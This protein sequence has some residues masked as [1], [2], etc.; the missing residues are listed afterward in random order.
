M[1]LGIT[2]VNVGEPTRPHISVKTALFASSVT[3]LCTASA[4]DGVN[5][6]LK[7][8]VRYRSLMTDS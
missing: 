4:A 8:A 1:C 6:A 7:N 3:P 2:L 5:R